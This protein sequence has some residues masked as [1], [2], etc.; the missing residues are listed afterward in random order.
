MEPPSKKRIKVIGPRNPT[1]ISSNIDKANILPYSR[2]L[3]PHLTY[4]NPNTYKKALNS[5]DLHL[6][7]K[8]ISKEL[9]NM[10]TLKIWEEALIEKGYKITHGVDFS[11]S[12][13]PSGRLN[14]LHTLISH[15]ASE[16]LKLKQL[17]IKSSFIN[18]PLEEY[19][20]L[21]IPQGLDRNKKIV[22]LK[23]GKSV[24]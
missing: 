23:L 11:K 4:S 14:S 7:V 20:Y 8:A 16:G 22:C 17:D 2:R 18:A 12:F 24:Y 15:E 13:A 1:L 19:V 6:W 21:S 3:S 10:I 5:V 9:N